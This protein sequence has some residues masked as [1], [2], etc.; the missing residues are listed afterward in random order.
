MAKIYV[1]SSWRNEFQQQLVTLIRNLGHQVYDFHHPDDLQDTFRWT[2][3]DPEWREWSLEQYSKALTH[4]KTEKGFKN[5]LNAIKEAD[6]CVLLLPCGKSAHTEAGWLKGKGKKVVALMC[7]PQEPE[8]MYKLFDK[9]IASPDDL[10]KYLDTL[11]FKSSPPKKFNAIIFP[12]GVKSLYVNAKGLR[13]KLLKVKPCWIKKLFQLNTNDL[14]PSDDGTVNT[15]I[16]NNIINMWR[17]NSLTI[18]NLLSLK[19]ILPKNITHVKFNGNNSEPPAF[20]RL[21]NIRLVSGKPEYGLS[22]NENVFVLT[23]GKKDDDVIDSM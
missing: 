1:A 3:I 6:V 15:E 22:P 19:K 14:P 4:P 11:T 8:F 2:D 12:G 18:D 13:E 23:I 5:H 21:M 10:V 17:E 9:V 7:Q 16:T 20:Y